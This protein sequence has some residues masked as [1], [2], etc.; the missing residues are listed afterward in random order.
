MGINKAFS[1]EL[2]PLNFALAGKIIPSPT[3]PLGKMDPRSTLF[4]N[5]PLARDHKLVRRQHGAA[6]LAIVNPA[7]W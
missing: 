7:Q 5:Q 4:K 6:G 3:I 1:A 2:N